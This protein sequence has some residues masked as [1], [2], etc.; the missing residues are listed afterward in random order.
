MVH[1]AG[2]RRPTVGDLILRDWL[3]RARYPVRHG[4]HAN[5][6]FALGLVLDSAEPAGLPELVAPGAAEAARW[7]ADDQ[8]G[9]LDWEPSG[10]DFLS[11]ALTEAD[12]MRR[13]CAHRTSSPA[14]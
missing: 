12:A 9:S 14:G 5:S 3:P 10:Q 6:A 8:G 7:F 11:P 2:P 4:T 1:R 13:V